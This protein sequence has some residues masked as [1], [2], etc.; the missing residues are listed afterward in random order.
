MFLYNDVG[1]FFRRLLRPKWPYAYIA[2]IRS[3]K[4]MHLLHVHK[5]MSHPVIISIASLHDK[6]HHTL[7]IQP[8][9]LLV[10]RDFLD[11]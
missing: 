10:N 5:R 1:L 9:T 6:R 8:P 7:F 2:Y 4:P 11:S 3:Y